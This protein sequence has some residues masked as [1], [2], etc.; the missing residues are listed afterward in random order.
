[1]TG[2]V[3][4]LGRSP[5][6]DADL[7]GSRILGLDIE[8][9]DLLQGVYLDDLV[10]LWRKLSSGAL[11]DVAALTPVRLTDQ[12]MPLAFGHMR[13]LALRETA[14]GLSSAPRCG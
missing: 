7:R 1:M 4:W 8:N 11:V 14:S 3:G 9:D 13:T 2:L 6:D 10:Q 12:N 5:S